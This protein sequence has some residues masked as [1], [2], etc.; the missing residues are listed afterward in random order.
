MK[1]IFY[2]PQGVCSKTMRISL[3]DNVIKEVKIN[4]GCDGNGKA[5]AQLLIG[6]TREAAIDK[7]KGIHC[8]NKSTSCADQLAKALGE[9]A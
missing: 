7:L 2:M 8:G 6:M 3:E 1:T 5:I 9:E 4:G